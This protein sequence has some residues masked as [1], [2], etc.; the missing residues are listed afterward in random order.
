MKLVEVISDVGSEHGQLV[1]FPSK[2]QDGLAGSIISVLMPFSAICC[3]QL[4]QCDLL[5]AAL[6]MRF[7]AC[8]DD[9]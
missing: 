2:K 1:L 6:S 4:S 7:A 3:M 8:V 5:H 9:L